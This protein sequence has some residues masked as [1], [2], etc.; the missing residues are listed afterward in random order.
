VCAH[1]LEI[2]EKEL[3]Q[4]DIRGGLAVGGIHGV[5][6]CRHSIS[7]GVLNVFSERDVIRRSG[8]VDD[9]RGVVQPLTHTEEGAHAH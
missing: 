3:T 8:V 5:R 6:P 9:G 1:P 2:H 4:D 7:Y